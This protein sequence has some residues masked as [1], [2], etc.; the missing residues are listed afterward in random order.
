M[1][2]RSGDLPRSISLVTAL[3][4]LFLCDSGVIIRD[5]KDFY[6][7]MLS[8]TG[9]Y[10]P[11]VLLV[12]TTEIPY[13]ICNL[14]NLKPLTYHREFFQAAPPYTGNLKTVPAC[15][16]NMI[17]NRFEL[18]EYGLTDS[19][20]SN[21]PDSI[22]ERLNLYGNKLTFAGL[23]QL[24]QKNNWRKIPGQISWD[25]FLIY[26]YPEIVP[27]YVDDKFTVNA[28]GTI[29]NNTHRWYKKKAIQ[30]HWF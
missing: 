19:S 9:I 13:E 23:E 18:M 28:G 25:A 5:F 16:K 11:G 10:F 1:M 3:K 2:G 12:G 7:N 6:K 22:A 24:A 14:T 29:S 17:F 30:M 8:L 15:L 4:S 27:L 21:L 26:N 20:T